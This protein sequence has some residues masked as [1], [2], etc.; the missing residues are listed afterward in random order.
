M[1]HFQ[2]RGGELHAEEVPLAEVAE[3]YGTPCYVY[4]RA[5]LERHW[6]A[7]DQALAGHPHLICYAVKANG[8]LAVLDLLARLGSGFDIVSEGELLRCLRAG[9]E[10]GRIVFSGVGKREAELRRA[11]EAGIRCFNVESAAELE[12]LAGVARALGRPAPVALRVNPEVDPGTHPYIATGLRESKFGIPAD[13]ALAL[14][15]RAAADPWLEVR[16]IDCHIGSQLTALD[17]FVDAL[18]RVLALADRLAEEGI[19]L[20]HVDVG[21]GLGIPYRDERPPEPAAYARALLEVLGE[22]PLELLLEP[23]RAIAGN[24]GVL[25][26]RVEYLKPGPERDFAI[27][28]AGMNDLLRPA[29][30]G[31]WQE[32]VPVR[33]RPGPA[34]L[35]DVVGPVCE[36]GDFLGRGRRLALAPG[37]LLA[38]RSAGAYGFVMASNYNARP[39]PPEVVVDGTRCH[40]ARPREHL[41]ALLDEER[42]LPP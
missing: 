23:G 42:P 25:L 13:E 18:E 32:I 8:N 29:L 12:R 5:T 37:D 19:A 21:G 20:A 2:Y 6:R 33:P 15:R 38:V 17:P 24:A 9:A 1:D 10:P 28:D 35:Y 40:L 4:S 31:A 3:R 16:G 41:E 26:T 11:L 39:R 36:S 14:Y 34:R 30:Y 22:R 7:F 27:V